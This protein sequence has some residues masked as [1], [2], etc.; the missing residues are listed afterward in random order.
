MKR[1]FLLL[2][3]GLVLI[4]LTAAGCG[5]DADDSG[6]GAK[7]PAAAKE[8]MTWK[9]AR[10]GD[11]LTYNAGG[12]TVTN[13]VVKIDGDVVH[14]RVSSG[15]SSRFALVKKYSRTAPFG[16]MPGADGSSMD[17]AEVG[18]ETLRVG[19]QSLECTILEGTMTT[20]GT[21]MKVKI[22]CSPKIPGGTVR[23]ILTGASENRLDLV[24]YQPGR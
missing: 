21:Q 4:G 5:K 8:V 17:L 9:N 23:K 13:E 6:D 14:V 1:T 20:D 3:A 10:V 18:S 11:K 19:G 2:G 22:W 24:N 12:G 7:T 16:K 15:R